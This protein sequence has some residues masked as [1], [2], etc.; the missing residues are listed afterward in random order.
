MTKP[1]KNESEEINKFFSLNE[2]FIEIETRYNQFKDDQSIYNEFLRIKNEYSCYKEIFEKTDNKISLTIFE[3][4]RLT[5]SNFIER[6]T[7]LNYKKGIS[8]NECKN[9]DYLFIQINEDIKDI[10]SLRKV[11]SFIV[12]FEANTD[13]DC[14]DK[15]KLIDFFEKQFLELINIRHINYYNLIQFYNS[16]SK[17]ITTV[18]S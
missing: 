12:F 1:E 13:E 18:I 9:K 15:R 7:N 11:T 17:D 5:I 6:L 2:R 4:L 10:I 16:F 3:N 14:F 8:R